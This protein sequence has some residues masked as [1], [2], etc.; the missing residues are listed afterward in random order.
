MR[1]AQ[2][3]RMRCDPRPQEEPPRQKDPASAIIAGRPQPRDGPASHGIATREPVLGRPGPPSAS[4]G[5]AG[6]AALE[7]SHVDRA[8]RRERAGASTGPTR[9]GPAWR[10]ADGSERRRRKETGSRCLVASP[11]DDARLRLQL[12]LWWRCGWSLTRWAGGAAR[13]VHPRPRSGLATP[14]SAAR[15]PGCVRRH[16]RSVRRALEPA[17]GLRDARGTPGH[18]PPASAGRRITAPITSRRPD[19][20]GRGRAGALCGAAM[21]ALP[22]PGRVAPGTGRR[23]GS[24]R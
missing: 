10:H 4:P 21:Q 3:V 22:R 5:R 1:R 11:A 18:R 24:R 19:G 8:R 17:A 20:R 7:A 13:P 23:A 9:P 12:R 2:P 6:R 15:R 14:A 16:R